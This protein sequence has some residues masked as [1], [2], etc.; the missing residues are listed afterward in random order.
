M[1][2]KKRTIGVWILFI[3]MFYKPTMLGA[4]YTPI[5]IGFTIVLL[6]LYMYSN[7]S[8]VVCTSKQTRIIWPIAI[9]YIYFAIR[10]MI[11]TGE[12]EW[13][14]F[15]ALLSIELIVFVFSIMFTED[16]ILCRFVRAFIIFL[17]IQSCSAFV[18]LLLSVGRTNAYSLQVFSIKIPTYEY[19][20]NMY[21]P[22]TFATGR[23]TIYGRQILRL[24]AGFRE[25][26]IA[27]LFYI[28]ALAECEHYFRNVKII[29]VALFFGTLICLSTAGLVSLV[30][31]YVIKILMDYRRSLSMKQLY[32]RISV[33]LVLSFVLWASINVPGLRFADKNILSTGAR[34]GNYS[35]II[36]KLSEN[37]LWGTGVSSIQS[38]NNSFMQ[39]IYTKGIVGVILYFSIILAAFLYS[40]NKRRFILANIANI[41]TLLFSQ[42]IFDAPLCFLL[43]S[44]PYTIREVRN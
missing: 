42:P 2:K 44:I 10:T 41:L 5:G 11:A 17:V 37:Y 43:L 38:S 16:K 27:Q 6:V 21:F 34:L 20:F 35:E 18:S 24:S 15:K 3:I 9:Y 13:N 7:R 4:I 30:A 19:N 1:N 14:I 12:I 36:K 32:S 26:G 31:Y 8:G 39:T 29:K 33:V 22:I 28:W 40:E 23:W 25:C